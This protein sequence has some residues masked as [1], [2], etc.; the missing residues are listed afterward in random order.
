MRSLIRNL[1]EMLLTLALTAIATTVG[2]LVLTHPQQL[3]IHNTGVFLD[4]FAVI[5]SFTVYGMLDDLTG[6]LWDRFVPEA[7]TDEADA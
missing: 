6:R 7:E 3:Q 1:A 4:A 2:V 5:A